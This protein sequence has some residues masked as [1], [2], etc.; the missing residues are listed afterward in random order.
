M[1]IFILLLIVVSIF[2]FVFKSRTKPRLKVDV[3]EQRLLKRC[4]GDKALTERL[5][6]RELLRDPNLSRN[7]AAADALESLLKDNR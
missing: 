1:H 7:E 2:I 3:H 6:K 4:Y 5:I